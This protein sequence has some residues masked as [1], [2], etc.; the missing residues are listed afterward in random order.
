[1]NK[2]GGDEKKISKIIIDLDGDI[3]NPQKTLDLSD[4][5]NI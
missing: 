3:T 4:L 5:K 2:N 1:M